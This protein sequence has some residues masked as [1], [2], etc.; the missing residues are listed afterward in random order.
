MTT[1]TTPAVAQLE[2]FL[3]KASNAHLAMSLEL[4]IIGKSP[5]ARKLMSITHHIIAEARERVGTQAN[6]AAHIEQSAFNARYGI[7]GGMSDDELDAIFDNLTD[8]Q[9]KET[10]GEWFH[11]VQALRA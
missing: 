8:D 3:S 10:H 4:A 1:T 2:A 6:E 7:T 9:L 5:E 11:L